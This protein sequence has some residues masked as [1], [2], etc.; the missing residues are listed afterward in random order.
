LKIDVGFVAFLYIP[1]R[2]PEDKTPPQ[3]KTTRNAERRRRMGWRLCWKA[4]PVVS[5]AIRQS[6]EEAVAHLLASGD[7][8]TPN[9]LMAYLSRKRQNDAYP[10]R[11]LT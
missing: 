8:E 5:V 4:S 11:K 6:D 2:A 7:L 10:P 9:F 1:G 3:G